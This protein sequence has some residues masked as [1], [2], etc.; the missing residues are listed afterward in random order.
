MKTYIEFEKLL[1]KIVLEGIKILIKDR[2]LN[3]YNTINHCEIIDNWNISHRDLWDGLILGYPDQFP[4]DKI[5][6]TKKLLGVILL[7]NSNHKII[8]KCTERNF[9]IKRF[10]IQL[11][12]FI[13]NYEKE[14]NLKCNFINLSDTLE[15]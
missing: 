9:S 12:N 8:L 13:V 15:L 7:E 3:Y 4:Y 14:N 10:K 11:N 6:K 5:Y 1:L 2:K